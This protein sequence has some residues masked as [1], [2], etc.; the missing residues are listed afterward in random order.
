M[1]VNV[2][3]SLTQ[4]MDNSYFSDSPSILENIR[5]KALN[6]GKMFTVPQKRNDLI[7]PKLELPNEQCGF[8]RTFETKCPLKC[9]IEIDCRA[10]VSL[11]LINK[12]SEILKC[13]ANKLPIMV[14]NISRL[15]YTTEAFAIQR[16]SDGG[17]GVLVSQKALEFFL[18]TDLEHCKTD[19]LPPNEKFS[20]FIHR[21]K[22]TGYIE[23]IFALAREL[24]L[25]VDFVINS[26]VICRYK[27][28]NTVNGLTSTGTGY[29]TVV[30]NENRWYVKTTTTPICT[31]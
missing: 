17:D 30:H 13:Y 22:S 6:D 2:N 27:K 5:R 24:N 20:N 28:L 11:A 7:E 9:I 12:Q 15:L 19:D 10:V 31:D 23:Y 26:N 8:T 4:K 29:L 16:N 21:L 14:L 25:N 1:I 18:K 3:D